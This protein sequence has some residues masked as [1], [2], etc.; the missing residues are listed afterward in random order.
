MLLLTYTAHKI[1]VSSNA[2]C[3]KESL[4]RMAFVCLPNPN[5]PFVKHFLKRSGDDMGE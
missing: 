5:G 1:S 4:L 2:R 3:Q